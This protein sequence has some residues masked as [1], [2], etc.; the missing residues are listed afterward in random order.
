MR[1]A[2][3][4][5]LLTFLALILTPSTLYAVKLKAFHFNKG[6]KEL[7]NLPEA[8]LETNSSWY[9]NFDE[10]GNCLRFDV[11]PFKLSMQFTI[12]YKINH[13]ITSNFAVLSLLSTTTGRSAIEEL[14]SNKYK[15]NYH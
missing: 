12:C 14:K 15:Y 7:W 4:E 11:P 10:Y 1:G 8:E 9:F 13:D 2:L 3:L 6:L 5:C